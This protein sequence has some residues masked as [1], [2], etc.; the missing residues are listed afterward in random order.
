M[1]PG[2]RTRLFKV[3]YFA[4]GLTDHRQGVGVHDDVEDR[5]NMSV[6]KNTTLLGSYRQAYTR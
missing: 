2:G 6:L 3:I 1:C 4:Y 5:N